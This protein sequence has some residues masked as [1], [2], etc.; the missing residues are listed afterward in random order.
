MLSIYRAMVSYRRTAREPGL[1]PVALSR[2]TRS[3][4][5]RRAWDEAYRDALLLAVARIPD[6]LS[7]P[8]AH[9]ADCGMD[10]Y[11]DCDASARYQERVTA[12]PLAARYRHA[13]AAIGDARYSV[14]VDRYAR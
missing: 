5:D 9:R 8:D 4:D 13:R 6:P 14:H 11:C 10:G 2:L 1:S 12:I 3:A 7:D